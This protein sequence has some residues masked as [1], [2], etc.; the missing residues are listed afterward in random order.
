MAKNTFVVEVT[1]NSH[2][3]LP[4]SQRYRKKKLC[5][6]IRHIFTYTEDNQNVRG[7]V[8]LQK[9]SKSVNSKL[10]HFLDFLASY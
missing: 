2:I 4:S 8:L 5:L 6:S 7:K 9:I 10:V 1:F 3:R